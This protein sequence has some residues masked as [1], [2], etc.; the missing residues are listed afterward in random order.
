[1]DDLGNKSYSRSE[2]FIHSDTLSSA[3]LSL[4]ALQKP[5]RIDQMIKSPSY[6]L[7]SAFPFYKK[8][9]FLPLPKA[10]P[11]IKESK[12]KE[13]LKEDYYKT[14]KVLKKIQFVPSPLW[15]KL[16]SNPN[17][18]LNVKKE[19]KKTIL[20]DGKADYYCSSN[21]L[22]PK[23]LFQED[24]KDKIFME[25]EK[26]G[27]AINRLTNQAEEGQLF[28][29]KKTV[30]QAE[31]GLYF[32]AKFN[33]ESDQ[34]E[35]EE[36][37]SLLGDTGLGGKK[38]YG[39]GLFKYERKPAPIKESYGEKPHSSLFAL[40]LFC[41]SSLEQE[42]MSWLDKSPVDGE[43]RDDS[44]KVEQKDMSWLDKSQYELKKREGWI[45]NSSLRRKRLFMF[46]EA[47]HFKTQENLKGQI[48]DVSPNIESL[49]HKVFRD[50]RG[51]FIKF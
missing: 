1:M 46:A 37:L 32:L 35:F 50:G 21:F 26:T 16:L 48:V 38:S 4:W 5:D 34:K 2:S 40:S 3:L 7:S 24:T 22:F 15:E 20:T 28:V 25:E 44:T 23:D 45:H 31:G 30:Y 41:P 27:V 12:S 51:F 18:F 36:I 10:R 49:E 6:L 33:T 43:I 39:N 19:D 11:L 13:L 17:Y 8:F 9:F 14:H 47:S 29:F 42:D